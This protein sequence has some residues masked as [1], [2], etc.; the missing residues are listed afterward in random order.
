MSRTPPPQ[1]ETEIDPDPPARRI[2]AAELPHIEV[3][4]HAARI[5]GT[6]PDAESTQPDPDTSPR[7]GGYALVARFPSSAT[8]DVFLGYKI[9][10]FGFLRRAVVKWVDGRRPDR[11]LLEKNLA[12]E[13]RA[14]SCL[15]HPNVVSIFDFESAPE[16]AHL[17][18]EYVAGTD[19]RRCLAE[20][21]RR[22]EVLPWD[23]ACFVT[24]ELLRGLDHVHAAVD[25]YGE[26]L[27]I[28]HRDVNPS[29]VLL[30]DDGRV[31]LTDFGT[32]LMEGRLQ[33]R[34]APGMVKG[35]VRYLAPEYIAD[36]TCSHQVDVYGAGVM[37]FEML[38][39]RPSFAR[40]PN[41][42]IML[43]IVREGLD[44]GALREMR[45]P[46][47]LAEIVRRATAR[48]PVDRY[49]SALAMLEDLEGFAAAARFFTSPTRLAH[50]LRG[51]DLFC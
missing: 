12:D 29:N 13:A 40:G 49:P 20:L 11:A 4:P 38:S 30:G 33:A 10:D 5:L 26:S 48:R 23:H 36:Q 15:D 35:K 21:G 3:P 8:A 47:A 25:P 41:V 7:V 22:G 18:V 31:K 37:L 39:G 42:D 9:T 14:I 1:A 51:R 45:V 44:L 46:P 17:A 28:I 24:C 2:S 19:L 50:H 27:G 16:G 6:Q 34:T 32:V 43:R